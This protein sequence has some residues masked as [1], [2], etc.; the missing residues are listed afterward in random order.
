MSEEERERAKRLLVALGEHG[1]TRQRPPLGAVERRR[2][3]PHSARALFHLGQLLGC[4]LKQPI[5]RIGDHRVNRAGGLSGK[6][7][8]GV[9][10]VDR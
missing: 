6:P 8:E 2:N 5:G 4:V 3:P 7:V 1:E 9:G 10:A